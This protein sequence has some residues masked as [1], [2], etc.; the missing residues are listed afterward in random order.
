MHNPLPAICRE[1]EIGAPEGG[2]GDTPDHS[3]RT[4]PLPGICREGLRM[5][6]LVSLIVLLKG[7]P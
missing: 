7:F 1:G 6:V 3:H 4:Y 5:I 2:R